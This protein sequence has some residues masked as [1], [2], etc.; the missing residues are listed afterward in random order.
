MVFSRF[1]FVTWPEAFWHDSYSTVVECSCS[2]TRSYG[3]IKG[4][5]FLQM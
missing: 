5:L 3:Q 1:L 2:A 4:E